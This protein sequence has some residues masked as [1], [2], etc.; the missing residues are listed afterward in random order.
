[1]REYLT[2]CS[3]STQDLLTVVL[4]WLPS[5]PVASQA[6]FALL[7]LMDLFYRFYI[8]IGRTVCKQKNEL[9]NLQSTAVK[10]DG[11]S[12]CPRSSPTRSTGTTQ[13]SLPRWPGPEL[14]THGPHSHQSKQPPD[15]A[16]PGAT[17]SLP[18]PVPQRTPPS[19]PPSYLPQQ[20]REARCP[21]PRSTKNHH[22]KRRDPA[23]ARP[24]TARAHL[25]YVE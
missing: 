16:L 8:N 7:Y 14:P 11:H 10:N 18:P 1:M 17:L 25:L 21:T 20:H 3:I 23:L 5:K 4:Q 2:C 24:P 12:P 19:A 15:D 22:Q 6:A 9:R 13:A